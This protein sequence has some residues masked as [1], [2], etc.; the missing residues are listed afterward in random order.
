MTKLKSSI[1]TMDNAVN[2]LA[3]NR[4]NI[5]Q[6]IK[7]ASAQLSMV[8]SQWP[9][10]KATIPVAAAKLNSINESD[11]DNLI[12]F[13][14]MDQGDVQNYFNSPVVIDQNDMYPIKNYG[15]ALAPFFIPISYG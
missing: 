10:I 6:Q 3:N 14:N 13:S 7:E 12:A 5:S 9:T 8:N 2:L 15:S 4:S 1:D 11:I